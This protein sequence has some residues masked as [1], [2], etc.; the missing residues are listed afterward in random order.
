[1]QQH[2]TAIKN[3]RAISDA[4]DDSD[5]EKLGLN[6]NEARVFRALVKNGPSIASDLV[7]IT[8]FHRNIVYDNLDKLVER[9]LAGY[10][11]EDGRRVYSASAPEAVLEMLER[12][13]REL[14]ERGRLAERLLPQLRAESR[15]RAKVQAAV[16]YRGVNGLRAVLREVLDAGGY[17]TM[18][19]S[20]E[21]VAVMGVDYWKGFIDKV[22]KMGVRERLLLNHDFDL[23]L[24]PITR[25]RLTEARVLPREFDMPTEIMVY[26]DKVAVVVYSDPPVA[27]VIQDAHAVRS[28]TRHFDY[29]WSLS[30]RREKR[31]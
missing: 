24:L 30:R 14:D 1:M 15:K 29:L 9:G 25:P 19:V 2:V 6:R 26:G 3:L 5:L 17:L 23:S 12:E 31:G 22:G 13:R 11:V 27:T 18:G 21:S 16:L 4:M 8:G 7:R 10:I 28:F 20:N